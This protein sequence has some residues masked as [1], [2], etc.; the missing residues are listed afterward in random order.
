[1]EQGR[2]DN[3]HVSICED[4]SPVHKEG[5]EHTGVHDEEKWKC[6]SSDAK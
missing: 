3:L 1:M 2:E 6:I 4:P 5:T